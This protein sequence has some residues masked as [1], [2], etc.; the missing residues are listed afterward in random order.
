MSHIA[1]K[2]DAKD[3]ALHSV[4]SET[5][6]RID[7]FQRDY[8]W[9]HKQIDALISDLVS[10][11]MANYSK[12]HTLADVVKYD[13][14]YMGPIVVCEDGGEMSVVDGQQRL[15]SFSL[16]LIYLRHLQHQLS[17]REECYKELDNYLFVSRGGRKTMCLDVPSRSLVMK[18]LYNLNDE[19]IDYGILDSCDKDKESNENLLNTYDDICHIFPKELKS[20]D[21][22][23]IFIEWLLYNVV[24]VEIKAYNVDNAY[25][26][27]ETMNDRG[28]SLNPTEILKAFVLSKIKDETKNEEMN[29]FWK[30]RISEIKY[31]AGSDGDLLFFRAWFRA[32]YARDISQG[33]VGDE[34]KDFEQIGAQFHTWFKN[35][36]KLMH[37]STSDNF[38]FFIKGDF[39]FFSNAFIDIVNLQKS[40]GSKGTNYF[41]INACYPLADSLYFALMF[42]PMLPVDSSFIREAKMKLVNNFVDVI[43]NRRTLLGKS[44]NQSSIRRMIFDLIK[45][46]RNLNLSDLYYTLLDELKKYD[47]PQLL[48]HTFGFSQNYCHYVFARVRYEL[49]CDST[50][51]SLLRTR[52]QSS[53]VLTQI[54]TNEEWVEDSL[55]GDTDIT[56]WSLHNFCLCKR[57]D[58][59]SLPS[60]LTER[61]KWLYTKGYL[62]E[63]SENECND[64]KSFIQTRAERLEAIASEKIW[65][66]TLDYPDVPNSM[67]TYSS[68]KGALTF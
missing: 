57:A 50:F 32:K 4:F 46:I 18:A 41:Y 48:S 66:P 44:V 15:S 62:P 22:L 58:S 14:Y 10:S 31:N 51:E 20:A 9:S 49:E 2:I 39:D 5:R 12:N 47:T 53:Y 38:Y 65:S 67:L 43:V 34:K 42:S 6:Y 55:C 64:L 17:L 61:I 35:N 52:K 21:I 40:E 37:L 33:K 45:K 13:C 3:K 19:V 28:L 63:L 23:P 25:T 11:F 36:Y 27:F 59:R 1:N 26:I 56:P 54:F 16:L 60:N 8:R 29:L 7:S 68:L 30:E 24:L